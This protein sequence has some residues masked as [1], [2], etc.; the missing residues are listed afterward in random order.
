MSIRPNT[1][2]VPVRRIGRDRIHIGPLPDDDE[3]HSRLLMWLAA[4]GDV[5]EVCCGVGASPIAVT[6]NGDAALP[7]ALYRGVRDFLAAPPL[8]APPSGV[9]ARVVR[10][11]EGHAR[12]HVTGVRAT[13][14]PALA[15]WVSELAGVRSATARPSTASIAV[16]FDSAMLSVSTLV[17]RIEASDPTTWPAPPPPLRDTSD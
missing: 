16:R 7:G 14:L 9:R 11:F 15:R 4:R 1:R 10:T 2:H 6:A 13:D 12:L 3:R 5:A 8:E 17:R